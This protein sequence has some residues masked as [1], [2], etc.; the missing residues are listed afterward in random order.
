MG[1]IKVSGIKLYAY[2]GCLEEEAQIGCH[3]IVDVDIETDFSEAAAKDD[4]NKTVD[5]VIVYN[6]VKQE[7]EIRS[8]LIEHVTKR[9]ADSLLKS[10]TQIKNVDVTVKK[11]NPP[12]NGEIEYAS[13]TF[14]AQRR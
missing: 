13:V 9:I 10:I 6:I 3:Y 5:Y 1:T 11:L 14:T 4:L 2:H 8:R 12:V 7:M